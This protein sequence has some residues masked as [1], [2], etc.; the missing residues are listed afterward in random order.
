MTRRTRRKVKKN[1]WPKCIRF[2]A[3]IRRKEREERGWKISIK[4]K[5]SVLIITKNF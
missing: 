1:S 5:E 3:R 2:L 4:K